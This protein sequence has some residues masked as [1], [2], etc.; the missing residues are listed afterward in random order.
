M[1]RSAGWASY[2]RSPARG[3]DGTTRGANSAQK[4]AHFAE[5]RIRGDGPN[6]E[7]NGEAD[8]QKEKCGL[9]P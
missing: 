3:R 7:A 1:L 2:K 4:G 5:Y 9:W 6:G 8:Q